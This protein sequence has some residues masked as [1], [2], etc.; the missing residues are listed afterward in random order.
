MLKSKTQAPFKPVIV[1]RPI[2]LTVT[3]CLVFLFFHSLPN[4]RTANGKW[5]PDYDVED[6]PHFLYHSPYREAPDYEYE[7]EV[8]DALKAVEDSVLSGNGGDRSAEQRIWQ[9]RLGQAEAERGRDSITFGERNAEWQYTLVTDPQ[10]DHF[11][12][13]TLA[14]VPGLQTLYD[15]YPYHVIRSDLLRYLLLW[16]YGGYYADMDVFPAKSIK[17]CPSLHPVFDLASNISLAVGVEIDEPHASQQL[18]RDWH[19]I[20]TYGLA[21]YTFFAPQRFS[22]LLRE[23]IVRVLSH[24]RQHNNHAF[25]LVGP[26]YNEKAILEVTG[27]GV[28]TDAI[29]DAL[30]DSLPPTHPLVTTSVD[31]DLAIGDLVTPRGEYSPRLTWRPFHHITQ[32]VCV[33]ANEAAIGKE[34]GGVCVLPV[35]AWGNGQRHSRAEGFRSEHAC[36]NHRFG[37]TWKKGWWGRTFG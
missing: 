33:D 24:T 15:S 14:P 2:S 3:I 22:P 1:R 6:L 31:E 23:V 25:P 30:S 18:M 4:K 7:R 26:H 32:P 27:P 5:L 17:A 34:M 11:I 36:V 16:F 10:A 13:T 20:R 28:F 29:L 8:S 37:G 19:W 9:I 35:N 21:Q 12:A